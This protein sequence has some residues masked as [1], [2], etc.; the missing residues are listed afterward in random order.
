MESQIA[1]M[2]EWQ[3]AAGDEMIYWLVAVLGDLAL[4]LGVIAV[5]I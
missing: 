5:W 1:G 2:L 4:S 3:M